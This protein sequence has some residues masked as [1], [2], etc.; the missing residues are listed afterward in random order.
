MRSKRVASQYAML[1]A[2]LLLLASCARTP[3]K[4]V[5]VSHAEEVERWKA[6]RLASLKSEEGWLSLVGLYWLKEGEN[7]FGSD[8]STDIPLPA[9]KAPSI[10]GSLWLRDGAVRLDVRPGVE[11]THDGKAVSTLEL[12]SDEDGKPTV[13]ALGT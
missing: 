3:Q 9:G 8:P 5:E 10:A 6:E 4:A 1:C 7:R 13:L 12:Q 11:I 2:A